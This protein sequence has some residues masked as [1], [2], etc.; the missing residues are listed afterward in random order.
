MFEQNNI[1]DFAIAAFRYYGHIDKHIKP[2]ESEMFIIIAAALT[3]KHF[4]IEYDDMAIEGI[5]QVYYKLPMGN[6][7]RGVMSNCVRKAAYDMNISESAL[8]R[9]LRVV[10]D[11]FNRYYKEFDARHLT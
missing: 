7:K 11:V 5:K 1:K 9:K 6:V 4:K 10:R 8:W 2:T 3:I